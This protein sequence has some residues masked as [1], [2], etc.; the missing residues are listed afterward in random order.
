MQDIFYDA[1]HTLNRTIPHISIKFGGKICGKITCG[2][3]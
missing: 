3:T 2:L 1:I